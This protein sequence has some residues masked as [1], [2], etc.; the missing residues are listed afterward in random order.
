MQTHYHHH[1]RNVSTVSKV[2]SLYHIHQLKP[3]SIFTK[4]LVSASYYLQR[5][6]DFPLKIKKTPA[7]IILNINSSVQMSKPSTR[8]L[9]GSPISWSGMHYYVTLVVHEYKWQW[10]FGLIKHYHRAHGHILRHADSWVHQALAAVD[11]YGPTR[12]L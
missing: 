3:W 4:L 8:N 7:K 6:K 1:W 9:K 10:Q 11:A 12:F 2:S 5:A